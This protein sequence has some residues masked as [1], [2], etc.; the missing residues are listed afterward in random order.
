M[1]RA[2]ANE[3]ESHTDQGTAKCYGDFCWHLRRIRVLDSLVGVVAWQV[4]FHEWA[5]MVLCDT[6]LAE[7]LDRKTEELI[8]DAI[9]NARVAEMDR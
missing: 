7:V 6:G 5:H 9:A 8:C 1:L 4:L 3:L 2:P